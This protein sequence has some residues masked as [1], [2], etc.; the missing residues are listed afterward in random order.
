MGV[1]PSGHLLPRI[2]T[3]VTTGEGTGAWIWPLVP[4]FGC[5]ALLGVFGSRGGLSP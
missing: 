3:G 4:E 5:G 1:V 2:H